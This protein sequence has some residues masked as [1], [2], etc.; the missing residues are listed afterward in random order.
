[1]ETGWQVTGF[2]AAFRRRFAR[3]RWQVTGARVCRRRRHASGKTHQRERLDLTDALVADTERGSDLAQ[4]QA[5]AVAR[6]DDRERAPL[7]A[8]PPRQEV[9]AGS[10]L[11]P[12]GA[13]VPAGCDQEARARPGHRRA[14]ALFKLASRCPSVLPGR[15]ACGVLTSR[16]NL[17]EER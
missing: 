16:E 17:S 11:A 8:Q 12:L 7:A 14:P 9:A 5:V 4:R 3:V 15:P 6:F 1:M 13:D 2:D 10:T